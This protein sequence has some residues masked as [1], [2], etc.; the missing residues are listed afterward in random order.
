VSSQ[1]PSPSPLQ[2]NSA[3]TSGET[4]L[5]E[6][7]RGFDLPSDAAVA[8]FLGLTSPAV[9]HVRSGMAR[10]GP[11]QRLKLLD[12]LSLIDRVRVLDRL[13]YI[14][15]R[16]LLERIAPEY[17]TRKLREINSQYANRVA[18]KRLAK[19]AKPTPDSELL[20]AFQSH[21]GYRDDGELG[22]A[23]GLAKP[24]IS[25]VR[26][27]RTTFGPRPRLRILNRLQPFD[28]ELVESALDSTDV[29]IDLIRAASNAV[30]T[31]NCGSGGDDTSPG[32][33]S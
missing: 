12:Q 31:N 3:D 18:R 33:P 16:G 27:G 8:A 7:R 14:R 32:A 25:A 29:L 10:L 19:N 11:T 21:F 23:L 4:L 5:D 6:I 20:E 1:P 2:E 13:G 28:L 24:T 30:G 17:L 26:T 15:A 22:E 9:S